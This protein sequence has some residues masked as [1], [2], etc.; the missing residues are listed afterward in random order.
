MG[1]KAAAMKEGPALEELTRHL[2]ECPP[3]F[4]AEPRQPSGV[5]EVNVAAVV[6]D[7]VREL[8]GTKL[9]SEKIR[10][11]QYPPADRSLKDRPRL[12]LSLLLCWLAYHPELRRREYLD[13]FLRALFLDCGPLSELVNADLFSA[14]PERREELVRL[15]LGRY[16]LRPK[17]ESAEEAENRFDA[18]SSVKRHEVVQAARMAER[19]A[20]KIREELAARE[21]ERRA[22]SVYT[23]E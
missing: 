17:G 21:A 1:A 12:R 2:A 6:S 15:L 13:G 11:L 22:A 10:A 7:F 23:Y 20:R 18:L 5:G 4:L 19:R 16:G 9:S 14:D 3:I 8:D